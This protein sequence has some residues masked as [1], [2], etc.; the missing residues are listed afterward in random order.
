MEKGKARKSVIR[1]V[2]V[3]KLSLGDDSDSDEESELTEENDEQ[4][5]ET[6]TD[7]DDSEKFEVPEIVITETDEV[8]EGMKHPVDTSKLTSKSDDHLLVPDNKNVKN[9][10]LTTWRESARPNQPKLLP[11]TFVEFVSDCKNLIADLRKTMDERL[12]AGEWILEFDS[13][14]QRL[15]QEEREEMERVRRER[16]RE[17][18]ARARAEAWWRRRPISRPLANPCQ[19]RLTNKVTLEETVED[20]RSCHDRVCTLPLLTLKKKLEKIER[21]L[22]T[23]GALGHWLKRKDFGKSTT[24]IAVQK[25]AIG[26]NAYLAKIQETADGGI[27]EIHGEALIKAEDERFDL[28]VRKKRKMK[29]VQNEGFIEEVLNVG[30]KGVYGKVVAKALANQYRFQWKFTKTKGT[31]RFGRRRK[32]SKMEQ[33][34]SDDVFA[35]FNPEQ[36]KRAK[37]FQVFGSTLHTTVSKSQPHETISK[38][39]DQDRNKLT[40]TRPLSVPKRSEKGK[41]LSHNFFPAPRFNKR[42]VRSLWLIDL[43]NISLAGREGG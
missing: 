16:E 10:F 28:A 33:K 22:L 15:E 37:G 38:E 3:P 40:K 42:K 2:I 29:A 9:K 14:I 17:D 25:M 18:M 43:N 32:K 36:S 8:I 41:T 1:I 24:R 11:D 7:D 21:V 12:D 27:L 6:D 34:K 31:L 23:E 20:G 4:D 35:I 30:R 13:N 26:F 5:N 19:P 39:E